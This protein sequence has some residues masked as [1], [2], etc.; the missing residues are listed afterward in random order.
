M[1]FVVVRLGR[2][3]VTSWTQ[4]C[5]IKGSHYA[6]EVAIVASCA[7][8]ALVLHSRGLECAWRAWCGRG[9]LI[10]VHIVAIRRKDNSRS[11][12]RTVGSSQAL[13]ARHCFRA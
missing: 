7:I 11:L 1:L 3:V 9:H 4:S 13:G 6:I 2:A 12:V 5:A 8:S 10:G